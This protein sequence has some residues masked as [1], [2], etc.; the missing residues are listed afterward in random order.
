MKLIGSPTTVITST[1]VQNERIT[2]TGATSYTT[3][4]AATT[5]VDLFING[6]YQNRNTYTFS[7]NTLALTEALL[8]SEIA[9]LIIR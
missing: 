6:V 5:N 4:N 8:T 7:G 2:G 1:S 3:V 9:E